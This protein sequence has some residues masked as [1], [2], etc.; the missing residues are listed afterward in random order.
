MSVHYDFHIDNN[1][2][3]Y[4]LT[5]CE[6]KTFSADRNKIKFVMSAGFYSS[7]K[8]RC[9]EEKKRV[10]Q[11]NEIEERY[12]LGMVIVELKRMSE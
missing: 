10:S 1:L 9:G 12:L 4:L 3:E 6:K 2:Q 5:I 7:C 11:K 8:K